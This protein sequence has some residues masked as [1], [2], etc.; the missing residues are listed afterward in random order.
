M[1][2]AVAMDRMFMLMEYLWCT[3]LWCLLI[4]STMFMCFNGRLW[5]TFLPSEPDLAV[6]L[7]HAFAR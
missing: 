5:H 2:M 7:R 6:P 4:T 1:S 3:F